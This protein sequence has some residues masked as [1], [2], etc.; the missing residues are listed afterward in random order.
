VNLLELL[1]HEIHD[2]V[3]NLARDHTRIIDRIEITPFQIDLIV[4]EKRYSVTV[5]EERV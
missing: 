3:L 2:I 1:A 4:G 5:Y